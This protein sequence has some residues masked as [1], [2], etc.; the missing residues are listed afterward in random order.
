VLECDILYK[1][2]SRRRRRRKQK[3]KLVTHHVMALTGSRKCWSQMKMQMKMHIQCEGQT[4]ST[5]DQYFLHIHC[6]TVCALHARTTSTDT[7]SP[8]DDTADTK[9]ISD[10]I[11]YL[12]VEGSACAENSATVQHVKARGKWTI[13]V[14]FWLTYIT[15]SSLSVNIP[16]I[17]LHT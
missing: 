2:L 4:D 8:D 9:L 5:D 17:I 13:R 15:L 11:R 7:T 1:L 3:I 10:D 14:H 12:K 16:I 6:T